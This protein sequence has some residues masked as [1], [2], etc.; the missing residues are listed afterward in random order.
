MCAR[1]CVTTYALCVYI[2]RSSRIPQD[3]PSLFLS[4]TLS[5]LDKHAYPHK[6]LGCEP[7][8]NGVPGKKHIAKVYSVAPMPLQTSLQSF[9]L[10]IQSITDAP[11][12]HWEHCSENVFEF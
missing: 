11:H 8:L 7:K 2:F 5:H 9:V 6:P 10:W 3:S 4:L 12:K 1:V